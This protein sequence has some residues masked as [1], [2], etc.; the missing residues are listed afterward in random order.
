MK[1]IKWLLI[2]V[3]LLAALAISAPRWLGFS[4]SKLGYAVEVASH[5]SA[6]LACSAY[7]ISGFDEAQIVDDLASYSPA[8]RLVNL[9]YLPEQ[10]QVHADLFGLAPATAQYHSATGCAL[11]QGENSVLPSLQK[12]YLASKLD[13][14][15]P[16]GE[17]VSG[18]DARLQQ[19]LDA[20]L[21]QDNQAG[22]NS[23][24]LLVVQNGR[25]LAES[26]ADGISSNTPLLGWSMAK[27][28]TA[29]LLGTLARDGKLEPQQQNLFTQWQQ[30]G[31]S[32]ISLEHLLQMR[33]G[34]DFDETYAPGSDATHMLFTAHSAAA[35]ALQS[36]QKFTPG[37]HFAYS[38]G[39]TNMLSHLLA[40]QLGADPQLSLNYLYQQLFQPLAMR[41]S[42]F[43]MDPSG[44]FVGSSYLYASGRD[45]ARLGW[46]L[47]NQGQINGQQL[48]TPEWIAAATAP[49]HSAN[50]KAYGYQFWL[51]RGD[52]QLRWP[53]LPA[54]AY[55][56]SGNRSQTV[57]M[58]PSKQVVLVRLG[59]TKDNYPM[60]QNFA[61]LLQ[62][63]P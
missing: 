3:I 12:P 55:A 23:R 61:R 45:W 24:A 62:Q 14:Q 17:Q 63:L 59:W 30:D 44:D 29:M 49:N 50:E 25:I 48:L 13:A 31:R 16:A 35:V 2:I 27:S 8:N 56:M 46:L 32:N 6:K 19:Q 18:Y 26:Y 60:A 33:S 9:R 5:M 10:Q 42:V 34:L 41:H 37:E 28:V 58:V 38:S 51:N 11:L 22:Y 1:W 40:Q 39:T 21:A 53:E 20:M 43:E 57:M 7:Y 52:A 36:P 4:L 15:W 54:D 47:L